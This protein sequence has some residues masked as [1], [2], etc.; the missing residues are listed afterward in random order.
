MVAISIQS[1]QRSLASV[2]LMVAIAACGIAAAPSGNGQPPAAIA[3][4]RLK[5]EA[6]APAADT[7][8]PHWHS[9]RCGSC[10][11]VVDGRFAPIAAKDVDELCLSC[12][13]GVTAPMERHPIGRTFEG[14]QVKKP[15]DWPAPDGRLSCLT[16]HDMKRACHAPPAAQRPA[17]NLLRGDAQGDRLTFCASCHVASAHAQTNPHIMRRSDGTVSES[18]CAVCHSRVPDAGQSIRTGQADLLAPE[19]TLCMGCHRRHVD[20]F[21]PGHF[22]RLMPAEMRATFDASPGLADTM[23]LHDGR[24]ACST[25]HN[26]HQRGVFEERSPLSAGSMGEV[27]PEETHA[28]RVPPATLCISCHAQ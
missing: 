24:V 28:L 27:W 1:L 5:A 9:A 26:P 25:C 16:C 20:F 23:P 2:V 13:D 14:T 22:D 17:G 11:A 8:N 6:H 7:P 18:A 21:D 3:S 19:R 12:H 10:H 15:Q 4:A